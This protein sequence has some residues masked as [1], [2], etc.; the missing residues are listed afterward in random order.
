MIKL[1][2][3]TKKSGAK[4]PN[5]FEKMLRNVEG[6]R[7]G[8][9]AERMVKAREKATEQRRAE[10]ERK[11]LEAGFAVEAKWREKGSNLVEI[12]RRAEEIGVQLRAKYAFFPPSAEEA[13]KK[14]IEAYRKAVQIERDPMKKRRLQRSLEILEAIA[15]LAFREFEAVY[16]GKKK[17]A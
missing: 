5:P 13:L 8:G 6:V 11:R 14:E 7:F 12:K 15:K 4:P 2:R 16:S 1:R 10:A 17:T 3:K 9:K